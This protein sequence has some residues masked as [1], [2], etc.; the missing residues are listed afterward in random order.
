MSKK[1]SRQRTRLALMTVS[2]LTLM[3]SG[4]VSLRIAGDVDDPG[5]YFKDAY[6]QIEQI[7]KAH[8]GREGRAHR[9]NLLVYDGS[10]RKVVRLGVP[11]WVVNACLE[12]GVDVS[13][14]NRDFDFEQ[15]FKVDWQSIK[16][17]SQVGPGLLVEA[18]DDQEKVLIW[19]K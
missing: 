6:A 2:G 10:E 8:P 12:A 4:C 7:H 19:L 18:V 13:E 15:R 5:R 17:L 9:L 11:M 16:D 14:H 1:M 3:L